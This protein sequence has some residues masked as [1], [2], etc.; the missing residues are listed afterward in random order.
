MQICWVSHNISANFP[1]FF[2]NV[3]QFALESVIFRRDLDRMLS[4]WREIPESRGR[5]MNF[6]SSKKETVANLEKNRDREPR[7][8]IFSLVFPLRG[9]CSS[10]APGAAAVPGEAPGS[11]GAHLQSSTWHQ[12]F[13][14]G[15]SKQRPPGG[16]HI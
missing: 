2:Q 11:R 1:D 9:T 13:A 3:A 7:F 6:L 8:G 12:C 5:S 15:F 14:T 4:E 10:R 16:R